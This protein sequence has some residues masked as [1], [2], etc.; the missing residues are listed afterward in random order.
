[1]KITQ[2]LLPFPKVIEAPVSWKD[3]GAFNDANRFKALVNP[4]T[5][6][7]FSI[8]SKDYR[9]I[10][11]EEAVSRLEDVIHKSQGLGQYEVDR[12]LYNKGARIRQ[13][14]RFIDQKSTIAAGDFVNP[15]LHLF[16]SYDVTWPFTFLLGAFRFV[17]GNGL[18]VGKKFLDF[19]RRHV[20]A[21][22]KM[23]IEEEVKTALERFDKQAGQWRR[24]A[25]TQLSGKAFTGIIKGMAF[26]EKA[27]ALI[28]K[29]IKSGFPG[30]EPGQLP[31]MT[32]WQFYNVVTWY[33]THHAAS[34]NHRVE[35]ENRLRVA[36]VSYGSI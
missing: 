33:I 9:L 23:G 12:A 29:H 1:M 16:N 30:N 6:Q 24:W 5:S 11:H 18:V 19:K 14:Y 17:C 34:L 28:G 31:A 21:L 10:R 32:L 22:E 3:H 13:T 35:L 4:D 8:V 25:S 15:E 36:M 26:G 2:K 20:Y 27:K 7:V